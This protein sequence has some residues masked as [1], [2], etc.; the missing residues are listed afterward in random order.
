MPPAPRAAAYLITATEGAALHLDRLRHNPGGF[1]P[2]V[3]DRLLAGALVPA[4]LVTQ[5]QKLR[6]QFRADVLALFDQVDVI[7]A[8]STPCSAPL[9]GQQ[10]FE[11]DGVTLPVRA[12]LGIFT[13][14]DQLHRPA[15]R[16]RPG[17]RS[18][19]ALGRAGDCGA[20]AGGCGVAGCPRAGA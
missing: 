20:V 17:V 8:P 4:T 2:A 3:R 19:D 15:R 18:G 1:D 12:N 16:G 5:A 10:T 13:P 14:A 7:L 6:R 9:L 11:L